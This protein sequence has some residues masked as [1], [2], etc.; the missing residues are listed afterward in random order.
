MK[1]NERI[2]YA[3]PQQQGSVYQTPADL[4]QQQLQA[5]IS[6]N[7]NLMSSQHPLQQLPVVSQPLQNQQYNT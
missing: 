7:D 2:G 3:Q 1:I 4:L 5:T 6:M